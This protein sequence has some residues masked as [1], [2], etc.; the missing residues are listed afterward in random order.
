MQQAE[1]QQRPAPEAV[2]VSSKVVQRLAQQPVR[3]FF[4]ASQPRRPAA[5]HHQPPLQIAGRRPRGPAPAAV[6]FAA[7]ARLPR[8]VVRLESTVL[9]DFLCLG[10]PE[11]VGVEAGQC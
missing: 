6:R 4:V 3:P 5:Y 1:I 11:S 2:A 7:R 9:Q 8:V 10:N